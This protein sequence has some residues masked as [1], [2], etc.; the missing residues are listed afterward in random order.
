MNAPVQGTRERSGGTSH[1]T[2]PC[3]VRTVGGPDSTPARSP[4]GPM[5]RLHALAIASL[6]LLSAAASAWAQERGAITGKVADK[7]SA[8]A[9]PFA[10]VTVVGAQKGALTDSEG[11]FLITGIEP[12]TYELR[13]QFLGFAPYSAPGVVVTAGRTLTLN[14]ALTEVVVR[15]DRKS[16]V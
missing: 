1:L 3:P 11:R 4:T 5:P 10:T 2:G 7:R 9:I 12:G 15:Q 6:I 16:V 14:V 8:H 13:V